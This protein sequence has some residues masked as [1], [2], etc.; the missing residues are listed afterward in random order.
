MNFFHMIL[1]LSMKKSHTIV[2]LEF[3]NIEIVDFIYFFTDQK[4]FL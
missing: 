4:S 2:E 1:C 3:Y